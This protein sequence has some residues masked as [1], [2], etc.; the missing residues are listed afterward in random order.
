M[1]SHTYGGISIEFSRP[2]TAEELG[3]YVEGLQA[4]AAY[5]ETDEGSQRD[6]FGDDW[7]IN[8]EAYG[9]I[10]RLDV[11]EEGMEV[12]AAGKVYAIEKAVSVFISRLPA[13]V[14][15]SGEGFFETEGEHWALRVRGRTVRELSVELQIVEPKEEVDARTLFL[16][17]VRAF[18]A[19]GL[20]LTKVWDDTDAG[21]FADEVAPLP[22]ALRP[23][24]SL[25]EWL[26][27]LQEHYE[28]RLGR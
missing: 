23:P 26:V 8:G 14:L 3:K 7:D 9:D 19:A 28:G 12:S 2:L 6:I 16:D 27:E 13:D 20:D 24:L 21:F 25:D 10:G 15:C 1:G 11:G 22:E 4:V 18:V 17:K 5:P